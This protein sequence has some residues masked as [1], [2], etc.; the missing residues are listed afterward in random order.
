MSNNILRLWQTLESEDPMEPLFVSAPVLMHSI[1]RNGN[2]LRVSHFWADMLGYEVEEMVGRKSTDFLSDASREYARKVVLPEFFRTG[3]IHNAAYDFVRADGTL[4]PVLMSAMAEYDDHGEYVRS[5][6]VMFDNSEAQRAAA[7]MRQ[8][9]RLDAIGSLVGGVAHDFNNLMAVI[10]GNLEFLQADPDVPDRMALIE[11]ALGAVQRGA[12]LT[13]QLL[14]YGQKSQLSP[15]L[16]DLNAVMITADRMVRRVFPANLELKTV[17]HAGLWKVRVD[18]GLYETAI[19]NILNNARDA[20]PDGG[21]IT[22]ETRNVHLDENYL[23]GRNETIAPGRYV[24]LAISDT[25]TGMSEETLE[26]AFEP[27]YTTKSVGKGTG[28][29][30]SMVFGFL[31]QSQGTVRAYSEVGVGTT[32]KLY[33]PAVVDSDRPKPV[34]CKPSLSLVTGKRVL[35]VEDEEDVRRLLSRQLSDM[36]LSVTEAASGDAAMAEIL[37]GFVPDLL[38]TDIVMP[39]SLQGPQLVAKVRERLLDMQVIVLSG[40]T[41]EAAMSGTGLQVNDRHLIKPVA[42]RD[43]L[44]AVNAEIGTS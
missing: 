22:M 26:R 29:G 15:S 16:V 43:L 34:L 25:G 35:L 5:L 10:Q 32:V 14:S 8:Q 42:Q 28:L 31:R 18:A 24:M 11:N 40:Y 39:G 4:V 20:T 1:D 3:S 2:L 17:T 38:V 33:L 6:A 23:D 13:R 41:S 21:C 7:Q 44:E 27:F 36:G 9:H 19:L 12:S 30:L 37:N